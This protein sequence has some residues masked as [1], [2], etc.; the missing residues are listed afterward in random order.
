[1]RSLGN[2][3]IREIVGRF[4]DAFERGDVG[5]ILALLAEDATFAMP[6]YA[7]WCRGR[8]AI[9]DSW[10]MPGGPAPR[11]HY[12]PTSANGQLALGV[13]RRD[14]QVGAYVPICLDVLAV[15]GGRISEVIA[16]RDF[17]EF[18]RF[19]L[20]WRLPLDVGEAPNGHPG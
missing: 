3:Q 19:G 14:P 10:L 9:A 7:G 4:V 5:A 13:Y 2:V 8:D 17:R 20:P 15:D 6:P 18:S 11:L 1:L 16:F 12:V